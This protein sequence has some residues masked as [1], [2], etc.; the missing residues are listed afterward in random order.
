M[1]PEIL[2]QGI[3]GAGQIGHLIAVEEPRPIAARD[4]EELVQR[5][6]QRPRCLAMAYHRAEEA[7][8]PVPDSRRVLLVDVVQDMGGSM[9]PAKGTGHVRP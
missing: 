2:F 3:V 5:R 1:R 7:T 8:Q 9:D 4:L 6:G